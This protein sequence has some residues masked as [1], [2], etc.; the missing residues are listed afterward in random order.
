MQLTQN[1]IQE[2]LNY[3]QETGVFTRR[4]TPQ[5]GVKEG[6]PVKVKMYQGY[7][8]LRID[9]HYYSAHR[10]AWLF[11][12][13]SLPESQIDHIDGNPENNSLANLREATS[14]QNQQNRR[15]AQ[16]NSKTGLLGAHCTRMAGKWKSALTVAGKT[17]Q[18]GTFDSPEEAHLAYVE[19]K[20]TH[21]EFC[22]I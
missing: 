3:D 14:S 4:E 6:S 19:A 7:P 9:R 13:G 18:L 17:F 8:H 22:T 5:W 11:V 1:R 20:R 2:L 10:I 15:A 12:T 16:A 21:H